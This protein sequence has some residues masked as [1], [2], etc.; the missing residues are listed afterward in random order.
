MFPHPKNSGETNLKYVKMSKI[1]TTIIF[2]HRGRVKDGAKGQLEI[3]ITHDRKN[4]YIGTGVRIHKS[5]W[6]AGRIV[7]VIGAKSLNDRLEIIYQKVNDEVN[8]CEREGRE[9]N[10][11]DIRKKV[12]QIVEANSNEP[13]FLNWVAEQIPLLKIKAATKKHYITL[14]SRLDEY[15][16]MQRWQDITIENIVMFDA[17]LH[18][19]RPSSDGAVAFGR[20]G[21]GLSDAAIYNYH[22][23]L[24]ALLRRADMFGKIERNP[25][26]RLRGQFNRGDRE[27]VEYLTKEEM[28]TIMKL[29]LS[30]GSLLA[31]C[32]D[33]F[34]FQMWT[35]L[36]YSDAQAFDISQY[37]NVNGKWLNVGERIKTGVPYISQLLP[38]VVDVLEKYD[39][40]TPKI[41]NHVYNRMLKAIG[42]MA[43]IE[44][45]LHSHLARHS[46]ATYM[47]SN[48][49]RIENVGK[50]LGQSN[51]K[52]T[53]RYAKVLAKDV[54]EDF[55][56]I[57][58]TFK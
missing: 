52:T 5:E 55:D 45:K 8:A 57:A 2:D 34:V 6:V 3:R 27:N 47:L 30:E 20:L 33:L 23:C 41:E 22:K 36:S 1:T 14:Q 32:R 42:A 4:I 9:I 43:G 50:M 7:G 51:I 53:Q 58:N 25:Y 38:P 48:G 12:W 54:H 21:E 19:L 56:K 39:W 24:K 16:K 18:A 46:F 26:E 31:Q 28:Q 29:E 13:T 44:T 17:W 49:T 40:K 37:K 10:S 15:G 11:D 35:G